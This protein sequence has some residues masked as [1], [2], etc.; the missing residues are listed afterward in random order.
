[1]VVIANDRREVRQSSLFLDY[2]VNIGSSQKRST[3]IYFLVKAIAGAD[4]LALHVNR[5]AVFHKP[6]GGSVLIL[7]STSLEKFSQNL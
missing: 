5:I 6:I 7:S 4:L 1:M 3:K 2:F